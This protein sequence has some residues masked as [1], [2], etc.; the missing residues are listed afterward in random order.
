MILTP[1]IVVL[2]AAWLVTLLAVH[3]YLDNPVSATVTTLW[4][5]RPEPDT[6]I[7]ASSTPPA[8]IERASEDWLDSIDPLHR[9]FSPLQQ[10]AHFPRLKPTRFLP[11]PCLE[12]WL[13][14]GQLVECDRTTLGAEDKLDIVWLWVNGSDSRWMDEFEHWHK[15]HKIDSAARHFR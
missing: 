3:H 2:L 12:S 5:G 4:R 10:D 8:S 9:A 11:Q 7:L 13:L 15:H 6:S 14:D 1:R